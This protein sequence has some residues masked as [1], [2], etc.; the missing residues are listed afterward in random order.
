MDIPIPTSVKEFHQ[1][2]FLWQPFC[3]GTY[4]GS[5]APADTQSSNDWLESWL[6]V[7]SFDNLKTAD[8]GTDLCII[9]TPVAY[10]SHFCPHEKKKYRITE[11]ETLT[12]M[13]ARQHFNAKFMAMTSQF[14]QTTL[15]WKQCLMKEWKCHFQPPHR[16]H[17]RECLGYHFK[18]R[19]CPAW[20][21]F[22]QV[23]KRCSEHA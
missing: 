18:Q 20:H 22:L 3:E 2:H 12:V 19:Y 17:D 23:L 4:E 11:L 5:W 16:T 8:W 13:W 15:L 9:W 1:A 14:T 21:K 7:T 6:Q 10:I